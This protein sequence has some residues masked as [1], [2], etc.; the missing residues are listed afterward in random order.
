MARMVVDRE[1]L[2]YTLGNRDFRLLWGDSISAGT[3]MS[4]EHVVLSL[5]AYQLTDSSVW[6]GVTLALYFVPSLL[7]GGIA[8]AI[9]DWMDRRDLIRRCEFGFAVLLAVFG[10]MLLYDAVTLAGVLSLS[11][12]TG[13]LHAL[14][15]P[16]RLSYAY[17]LVGTERAVGGLSMLNLGFRVG[18]LLGALIAGWLMSNFGAAYAFF[19]LGAGH[20]VG[21][22]L[23]AQLRTTGL[24]AERDS[25]SLRDNLRVFRG[26]LRRNK[27]LLV[28]IAVM[29]SV[30]VL[31]FSYT[32]ALPE[33]AAGDLGVG[34]AELGYMHAARATGGLIG[35]V[36]LTALG[37]FSRRG[38]LLLCTI[39]PF[40]V[41][42]IWV[43]L[44][45]SLTVI[46]IAL[47]VTAAA[48]A[49]YDV[50]TQSVLQI[51]VPNKLRGRAM[52]VW[53]FIVGIEPAG[54]VMLGI[55]ISLLG[56]GSA[57]QL[58]GGLLLL[59]GIVV[60]RYSPRLRRL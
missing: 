12:A 39:V 5:L 41:G 25:S 30:A 8:G 35:V 27:D 11:V 43:G 46:L 34:A 38:L 56:V 20:G 18:Q 44:S 57:M 40:G 36:V 45:T 24:A 14:Y 2:G 55:T 4:G 48:T 10:L 7:V 51:V 50:L 28:L 42:L 26:E 33:L 31:G 22:L 21:Y 17:D 54:H 16:A 59:I 32:T 29:V 23:L 13:L 6:V 1:V 37:L 53:V 9:A 47:V 49:I 58:N 15:S 60:F 19:A 3:G 52:G